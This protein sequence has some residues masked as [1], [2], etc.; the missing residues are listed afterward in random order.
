MTGATPDPARKNVSAFATW[1]RREWKGRLLFLAAVVVPAA[2]ITW[3]VLSAVQS[4]RSRTVP[5]ETSVSS[6][7]AFVPVPKNNAE[8]SP[9]Q[10]RE[11]PFAP[12]F[13]LKD[14]NG[15]SVSLSQFRGK[16]VFLDFWATWCGPCRMATPSVERLN[17]EFAPKGLQILGMNV[18]EDPSG[19]ADFV[20]SFGIT[21]PTLLVA[22]SGVD[23]V[24]G[25]TGIPAFLIIDKDGKVADGGMG[26]APQFEARWRRVVSQLLQ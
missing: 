15:R 12:N 24:Y 3:A 20:R 21:Y 19:V 26:F 25:V 2:G 16:V 1:F 4:W 10:K 6:V 14:L 17:A 23:A 9:E 18:D 11:H 22:G 13:T 7:P 8:R 5:A